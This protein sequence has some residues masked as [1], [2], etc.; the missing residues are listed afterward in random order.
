MEEFLTQQAALLRDPMTNRT[1]PLPQDRVNWDGRSDLYHLW[2]Y[3]RVVGNTRADWSPDRCVA[4]FPATADDEGVHRLQ[5]MIN[6]ILQENGGKVPDPHSFTGKPYPVDAP[7][8]DR[9]RENLGGDNRDK[10]CIYDTEMHQQTLVHFGN[11]ERKSGGGETRLLTH[12]YAFLF[13]EDWKQDLFYKRLVRDK[14]RYLDNLMCAAGRIIEAIRNRARQ[15]NATNVDGHYDAMHIRRGDFQYKVTRLDPKEIYE[16]SMDQL[17]EGATVFI[18]TDER[19]DKRKL[20]QPL[21]DHYDLVFLEDFQDLYK[22]I[23][24]NYYGMLDQLVAYKSRVFIGTWFSTFS[25]YI[26]RLRG[27]L[28]F[29]LFIAWHFCGIHFLRDKLKHFWRCFFNLFKVITRSNTS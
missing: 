25:G 27:M 14:V 7:P 2:T 26:N 15:R 29:F 20:L 6:T 3:L 11:V 1:V 4:A 5:S 22:D 13:F 12:F 18:A 8:I 23:G 24:N 21:A 19:K 28:Q 16:N 17:T 10:L 9:L